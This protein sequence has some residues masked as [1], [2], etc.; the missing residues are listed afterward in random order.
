MPIYEYQAKDKSG[1]TRS[2]QMDSKNE[3]TVRASLSK[4]NLQVVFIKKKKKSI[5]EI[6]IPFLTSGKVKTKYIVIFTRQLSTMVSAGVP[7]SRSIAT[8]Q[9]QSE[10]PVFRT[11]LG[12]INK[13]L[14]GGQTFAD[15]LEKHPKIFSSIFVNMVRAGETGGILEDILKKLSIQLEKD[16]AIKG[17]IKSAMTYPGVIGTITVIAFFFLMTTIVPKIGD[18]IV[19]LGGGTNSL[20]IYTRVLI[21]MSSVM[22]S[23]PFLIGV[24]IG[25]PLFVTLFKRYTATTKGRLVWHGML[26]KMPIVKT[27]NTKVAVARFA[28]TFAS[29]N[30]A[31]VSVIQ[32]LQVTAAAIGNAVIE[33]ELLEISKQVQAGSQL[34]A[35]LEKSKYFPTLVAQMMAVGE[36]TGQTGEVLVKVAEFYEEEVDVFVAS[37]S[38]IIEP[39]MIVV[40]GSIVG[41]IAASVFG[42]ISNISSNIQ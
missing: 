31:G 32:A 36:E 28:R 25:I 6:N 33:R 1:K 24:A 5:N 22:K 41:V 9:N 42:P 37:L 15:A 21:S 11:H 3:A 26:L 35:E 10:S 19:S 40:M 29:L 23:P 12:Q 16:A 20:P 17:K 14:E 30:S 38:S 18:I 13:D 27:L 4:N 7:L 2:G 8:L 39:L 34:S